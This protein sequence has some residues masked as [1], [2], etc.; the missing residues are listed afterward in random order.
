MLALD[1]CLL[2]MFLFLS[3]TLAFVIAMVSASQYVVLAVMAIFHI[4]S[5][6]ILML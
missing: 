5:D 6:V 3:E 4:D 1:E 2:K